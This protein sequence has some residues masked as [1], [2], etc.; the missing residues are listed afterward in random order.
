MENLDVLKIQL[1]MTSQG[2]SKS[3]IPMK[4]IKL[5]NI[6]MEKIRET[7]KFGKSLGEGAFGKVKIAHLRSNPSK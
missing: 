3:Q 5:S 1:Q 7:Y 2:K 4:K 6:S